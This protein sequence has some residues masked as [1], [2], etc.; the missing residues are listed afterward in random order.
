MAV[1]LP[2]FSRFKMIATILGSVLYLGKASLDTDNF[3]N[4]FK[5]IKKFRNRC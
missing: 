3:D 4:D 1:I 5:K 2:L